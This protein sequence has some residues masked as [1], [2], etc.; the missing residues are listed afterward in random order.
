MENKNLA[1][2]KLEIQQQ[3]KNGIDFILAAAIIW[4]AIAVIWSLDYSAY[5]RSIL[6]FMIGALLLPLA[7]TFSKIF[8]TNW[9]VKDNPLKP[10]GLWLNFAQ[11]LYFPFLIFVLIKTPEYF[12]MTY[13]IITG[14]HLFPYAWFYDDKGYAVT[15]VLIGVGALLIALNTTQE[16]MYC[17][18]L[19]TAGCL[20]MFAGWILCVVQKSKYTNLN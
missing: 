13:A 16:N 2:L 1:Q 20:I 3:A 14:A 9:K 19:I 12:V 11:L 5:S 18:P 6:T 8:K 10:L 4:F 7:F 17:L 15:A